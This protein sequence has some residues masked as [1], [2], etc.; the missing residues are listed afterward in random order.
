MGHGANATVTNSIAFGSGTLNQT[1]NT[2]TI[3]NAF[4]SMALH[5]TGNIGIE[6]G[7]LIGLSP[8]IIGGTN[9]AIAINTLISLIN[10]SDQTSGQTN[11]T[12]AAGVTGQIKII[13]MTH[14]KGGGASG[15]PQLG[16]TTLAAN[17][18]SGI[19]W[20]NPGDTVLLVYNGTKW[21][22]IGKFGATV[23]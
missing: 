2:M 8:E 9:G 23:G 16:T 6:S 3:G 14:A 15:D 7:A 10:D 22:C 20:T 5:V 19:S 21:A 18:S 11:F 17:I 1:A 4:Q 13:T 12:L